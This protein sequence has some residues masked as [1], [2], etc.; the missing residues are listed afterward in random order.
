MPN[1]IAGRAIVPEFIQHRATVDRVAAAA[2]ELLEVGDRRRAMQNDL[3]AVVSTLGGPG[4][5]DR[6]AQLILQEITPK[7][8][9]AS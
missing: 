7:T 3:A 9:T 1:V 6:A 8:P 2:R 5:S 4:A